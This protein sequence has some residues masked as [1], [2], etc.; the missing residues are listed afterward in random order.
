MLER[1]SVS[2]YGK[3]GKEGRQQLRIPAQL[4]VNLSLDDENLCVPVFVQSN[5]TLPCLL[6]MNAF[7]FLGIRVTRPSEKVMSCPSHEPYV[8]S[9]LV[10]VEPEVPS[11]SISVE[12][13]IPSE[14]VS[15]IPSDEPVVP[16]DEHVVTSELTLPSYPVNLMYSVNRVMSL[17]YLVSILVLLE[18]AWSLLCLTK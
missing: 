5:S 18:L 2:L 9:E 6:G 3:D 10:S 8:P 15:E 14:S 16:S 4:R 17:L 1:P 13:E 11:E 12:P 7:F